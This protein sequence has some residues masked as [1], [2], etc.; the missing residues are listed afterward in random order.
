[1]VSTARRAQ[2]RVA[3]LAAQATLSLSP[4][5][6]QSPFWDHQPCSRGSK[7]KGDSFGGPL[8]SPGTSKRKPVRGHVMGVAQPF[9]PGTGVQSIS[10]KASDFPLLSFPLP[11]LH[12]SHRGGSLEQHSSRLVLTAP[13]PPLAPRTRTPR[14]GGLKCGGRPR[15][16]L[17][18]CCCRH[19]ALRPP[20]HAPARKKGMQP[21]CQRVED[22]EEGCPSEMPASSTSCESSLASRA[23]DASPS[24]LLRFFSYLRRTERTST[25]L[26]DAERCRHPRDS[27]CG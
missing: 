12:P 5:D 13:S 6:G 25:L 22:E 11:L 7:E 2:G 19:R 15:A 18:L 4:L 23:L 9:F 27:A 10:G 20:R 17:G 16:H 8:T 1:V 14:T 3:V 21:C 24:P 26:F